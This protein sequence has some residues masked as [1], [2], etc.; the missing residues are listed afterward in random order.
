MSAYDALGEDSVRVTDADASGYSALSVSERVPLLAATAERSDA[1]RIIDGRLG[2]LG[3]PVASDAGF[4][5][6]WHESTLVDAPT[7][8]GDNVDNVCGTLERERKIARVSGESSQSGPLREHVDSLTR[9]F[10]W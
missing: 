2:P 4:A 9:H 6:P 3:A 7:A 1:A 8:A 10:D 5:P